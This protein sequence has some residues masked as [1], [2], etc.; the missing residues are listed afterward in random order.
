MNIAEGDHKSMLS[1][2]ATYSCHLLQVNFI[3]SFSS[4][5]RAAQEKK[6]KSL[7]FTDMQIKI[8]T[9]V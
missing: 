3:Y 1:G 5:L 8:S 9:I 2:Q 7:I 4:M 6:C